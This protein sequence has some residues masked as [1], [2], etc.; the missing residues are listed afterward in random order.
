M[1]LHACTSL[2]QSFKK[3][4]KNLLSQIHYPLTGFNRGFSTN[5]EQTMN[6]IMDM[7]FFSNSLGHAADGC[8]PK[9][10]GNITTVIHYRCSAI[11]NHYCYTI[12]MAYIITALQNIC[13]KN[14]QMNAVRKNWHI[15]QSVNKRLWQIPYFQTGK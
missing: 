12:Y 1:G 10:H 4:K 3:T 2:A 5:T 7:S 8:K 9:G 13:S 6:S 14:R 11:Y 15:F